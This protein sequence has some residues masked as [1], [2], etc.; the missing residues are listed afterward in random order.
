MDKKFTTVTGIVGVLMLALL[1]LLT[2]PVSCSHWC[3]LDTVIPQAWINTT[4]SNTKQIFCVFSV[5]SGLSAVIDMINMKNSHSHSNYV[6]VFYQE[7]AVNNKVI[8]STPFGFHCCTVSL[9]VNIQWPTEYGYK[10][11]GHIVFSN[12][13]WDWSGP[14]RIHLSEASLTRKTRLNLREFLKMGQSHPATVGQSVFK[15]N[16]W[17]GTQLSTHSSASR[18]NV[19]WWLAG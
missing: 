19:N 1:L 14:R 8:Y 16:P 7:V 3:F 6:L 11:S 5:I 12:A 18:G 13:S 2:V 4:Q 9:S 17:M 15:C 10:C